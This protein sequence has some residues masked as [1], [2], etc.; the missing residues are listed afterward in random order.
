MTEE[1]SRGAAFYRRQAAEQRVAASE[2]VLDNVR[3][4]CTRAAASWDAMAARAELTERRR[5]AQ[6]ERSALLR[7]SA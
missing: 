6:R 1:T 5:D 2:A 4:R 7:E 3:D